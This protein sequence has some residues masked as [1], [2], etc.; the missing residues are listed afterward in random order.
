VKRAKASRLVTA[1]IATPLASGSLDA[2][3]EDLLRRRVAGSFIVAVVL[4]TFLGFSSW[5]STQVAAND[6]GWV[7]H[8]YGVMGTLKVTLQNVTEVETSARTF[9]LIG[10]APLLVHY[11]TAR[12]TIAE[13]EKA[14]RH[15]TADNP[16]QQGRL[17]VLESRIQAALALAARMVAER[18]QGNA[19][20]AAAE[21]LET[22]SLMD[23]VRATTQ[24]IQTEE[25]Q[26]LS[27]R[28]QRTK[29]QQ[30]LTSFIMVFGVLVG[31]GLL[32]LAR[33]AINR[34]IDASARG[35]AQISTLNSELEQRVEQRTAALQFEIAENK[36]AKKRMAGQAE[37]LSRRA[38]EL[39]RSR[40]A[41]ETKTLM[42]RSVLDSMVE[43]LVAADEQ[44]A[45][46][47]WNP[48]AAK[49]LGMGA[50][51]LPFQEWT[52][53]YGLYLDD[54]VTPFPPDQ[55]PLTRAIRGEACTAE[56]FVRNPELDEGVW[57]E[58]SASPLKDR[59]R[60]VIGGVAAFRD[61]TQRRADERE[62]RKLNEE[63][64]E[65]VAQRTAQL[66]AANQEL[67][68]FAYSVSHDLRAP[69]RHI[70]GFSRILVEDFAAKMEPEAQQHLQRIEDG[71]RRMG[72]LVDELLN[73]ARVGRHALKLQFGSLN[74]II[75]E[76]VSL[77][78]P[79]AEGRG[80]DW[81]IAKLPRV[82]CD[83]I[84]I[85]Q[86]FQNLISNALKFTRTRERA[87][88]EIDHRQQRGQT[89][90]FVRDNGV[91]FDMKYT[92]KLFGVFQRLHRAEDFEG[93]G[94]GLAV[95][96]RIVQ[97]HGGMVW[98]Q[99]ELGK[100]ATFYFTLSA[101]TASLKPVSQN[102]A[103]PKEDTNQSAAA[104]G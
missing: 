77:L 25:T 85:R 45:V 90:I 67:E 5:R 13:D 99:A 80:V 65:R 29:A 26:L 97:K 92:D 102:E 21:I 62:I 18:Q 24:E 46:I 15:L 4:T 74:S 30:R 58:V 63:L 41:L 93:T 94:V 39:L 88:I 36:Q 19:V 12:D 27:Q 28:I 7:V 61:V 87:V 95:V 73:L 71:T 33:F 69:L 84:L 38:E 16:H 98:A 83:P 11:E 104:G 103:M 101:E 54:M 76:V 40:Q 86:V 100:G 60:A 96:Q 1:G 22:E 44:G 57:I 82:E 31:A 48:A 53:H 17:D 52:A 20:A 79:D 34:E 37:E 64:E 81:K 35:R 8:T 91:G 56:M 6:A 43:G 89:V 78:Q 59:D 50:T 66:E 47:I 23:A 70:G 49:I 51:G 10:Q 3:V 75:A 68:A 9:A 14:L 32:T 72:L 42:L 2:P 55:L